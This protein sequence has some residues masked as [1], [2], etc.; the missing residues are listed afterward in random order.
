MR[1]SGRL[2]LTSV[3][4]AISSVAALAQG[5]SSTSSSGALDLLTRVAKQY[6][7]AKSSYIESREERTFTNEFNHDWQEEIL[8]AA[9]APGGRYHFEGRAMTGSPMRVC[10]GKTVWNYRRNEQRY[11]AKPVGELPSKEQIVTTPDFPVVGAQRLRTNMANLAKNLHSAE[12][13]QD[14]TLKINGRRVRC[15]L[16]RVRRSDQKR[17]SPTDSFDKTIWIDRDHETIL[18]IVEHEQIR[19]LL[20][21]GDGVPTEE[22]VIT[23]FANTS[24]DGPIPDS[25]FNFVPPPDAKLVDEFPDP[26]NYI[27]GDS[28]AGEQAPSLK[29]KSADGKLV[30][31]DSFR[32]K[33][34]LIDFWA[35]WCAPCV[36]ALPDVDKIYQ[37]GR[38][39]GLTV[40]SVDRDEEAKTA[41]DMLAKKGYAW[42]NFHDEGDV[43][44]LIGSSGIPRVMLVNSGGK[45]VYDGPMNEDD[46]RSEIAKLGPEY[47][48]MG[49]K[50]KE[51]PCNTVSR[52][53]K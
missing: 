11:T 8:L 10:D 12:W 25:L 14:A 9:E 21:G 53:V 46:L 38:E 42:P 28:F 15:R 33:P 19:S 36:K 49:P 37:E 40:L 48:S 2:V 35:T 4:A 23:T 32:G 50:P 30:S 41:T 5:T 34:V 17:P 29:F 6:A 51:A 27:G 20:P 16:V 43:E 13:L 3:F 24:L 44:Q 18:K 1:Y 52:V 39:K 22:E 47:A 26:R 7:E 45:V 31:L